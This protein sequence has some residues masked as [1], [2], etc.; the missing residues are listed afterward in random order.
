MSKAPSGWQSGF[1]R[2]DVPGTEPFMHLHRNRVTGEVAAQRYDI[3]E[4]DP[5]TD[6]EPLYVWRGGPC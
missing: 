6:W 4:T 3:T 2:I 1:F 5:L